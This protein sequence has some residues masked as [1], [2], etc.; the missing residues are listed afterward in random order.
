M[1][2]S[3]YCSD[4]NIQFTFLLHFSCCNFFSRCPKTVSQSSSFSFQSSCQLIFSDLSSFSARSLSSAC[5]RPLISTASNPW[6]SFWCWGRLSA[7]SVPN[8][9]LFLNAFTSLNLIV[10]PRNVRTIYAVKLSYVNI[11][12]E[13]SVPQ[14]SEQAE[15]LHTATYTWT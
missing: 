15:N 13:V 3:L 5:I 11:V 7:S 1:Q 9:R 10:L 12:V 6:W 14:N 4:N 2:R 8:K